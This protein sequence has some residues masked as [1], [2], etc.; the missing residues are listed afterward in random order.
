MKSFT[1]A[2]SLS[3]FTSSFF[4]ISTRPTSPSAH[5]QSD[6]SNGKDFIPPESRGFR[7]R[8]TDPLPTHVTP[9]PRGLS[10]KSYV[11]LPCISISRTTRTPSPTPAKSGKKF[12]TRESTS[13]EHTFH[14]HESRC[15]QEISDCLYVAFEEDTAS[16][17]GL[18][19]KA[20]ELMTPNRD[21]FTHIVRITPRALPAP[22]FDHYY[23]ENTSTSVLDLSLALRMHSSY[24]TEMQRICSEMDI[25]MKG[26]LLSEPGPTR[27]ESDDNVSG[28]SV[29][30]FTAARD[31]IF[32]A[33]YHSK[34]SRLSSNVLITVPRD[35]RADAISVAMVYLGYAT[36]SGVREILRTFDDEENV[37]FVWRSVVSKRGLAAV[38]AAVAKR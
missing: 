29:K 33:L 30:Q 14:V 16:F 11:E 9:P 21:R 24:L 25:F 18:R 38:K 22:S 7:R 15:L 32:S 13:K 10:S 31:F 20:E 2:S 3:S 28:L 5:E 35:C 1:I 23:D 36:G 26:G 37:N 8:F 17:D 34:R 27:A 12:W 19:G 4:P 6:K